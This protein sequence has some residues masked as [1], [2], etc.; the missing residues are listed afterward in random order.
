MTTKAPPTRIAVEKQ[1]AALE[2]QISNLETEL[3]VAHSDI[4]AAKLTLWSALPEAK[5]NS[6]EYEIPKRVL[7]EGEKIVSSVRRM[8]DQ[9]RRK[10]AGLKLVAG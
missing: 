7:D 6:P 3:S 4:A 2:V 8:I 9:R 1:I 10:I 5:L